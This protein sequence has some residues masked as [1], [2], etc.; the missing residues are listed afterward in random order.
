MNSKNLHSKNII[1]SFVSYELKSNP[2]DNIENIEDIHKH[3]MRMG[4][5]KMKGKNSGNESRMEGESCLWESLT[6]EWKEKS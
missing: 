1:Y 3:R 6:Y 5:W 2:R 4:K